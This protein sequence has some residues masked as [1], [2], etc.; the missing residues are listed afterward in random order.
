M[1]T[2]SRMC[3]NCGG[4][5]LKHINLCEDCNILE[6]AYKVSVKADRW[7]LGDISVA[8]TRDGLILAAWARTYI[9]DEAGNKCTECGWCERN[10]AL[11]RPILTVDHVDGDWTNNSYYN[12][13]VLCYNCH[14]L[15]PTFGTLNL[16][17]SSKNRPGRSPSKRRVSQGK[18][19]PSSNVCATRGCDTGIL[20]TS[21]RCKRHASL[22]K[23]DTVIDW[24]TMDILLQMLRNSN[25]KAVSRDLDVSDNAIRK[26]LKVR[27]IDPKTL[28]RLTD[29]ES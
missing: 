3:N 24:P 25:F 1:T 27:G 26:R 14:S 20:E 17:N 4:Q 13:K 29:R 19:S 10:P 5:P 18:Q 15:T 7:K 6:K 11:D 8:T 16:G 12:L 28:L 22:F 9:L 21:T 23:N 2:K